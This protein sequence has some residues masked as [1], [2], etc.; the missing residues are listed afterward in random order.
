MSAMADESMTVSD[1]VNRRRSV[2]A[3]LPT[4]LPRAT[5]TALLEAARR[6]PSGGN[7]QPWRV[8]VLT[9]PPLATL[10]ARLT[11]R[12]MAGAKEKPHYEI[13]PAD[14]WEPHRSYRYK[15]GE[16]MYGHAGIAREDKAGRLRQLSAN[17]RFFGAPVG[18]FF[19]M[20]RGMGL[21]QWA[22]L[23]MLMQTIML[24]A[25]EHGLGTCAQEAWSLWPDTVAEAIGLGEDDILFAGMA[26]GHPD[27]DAPINRLRSNR[28][29][30]DTFVRLHGFDA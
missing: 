27:P 15:V 23:G 3:F 7:V 12:M 26:L 11:E 4:P 24:L 9:G 16:D 22:D 17:F 6:S 2:R 8:D 13:Y 30:L 18:L 10:T 21:G 28:A 25:V 19:S 29:E 5:V 1:A 20:H 14:L